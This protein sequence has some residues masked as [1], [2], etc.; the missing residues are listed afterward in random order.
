MQNDLKGIN[1]ESILKRLNQLSEELKA[2]ADKTDILRL[3]S[4]K[5][6]KISVEG[7]FKRVW[8]EIESLKNWLSQLDDQFQNKIK[9]SSSAPSSSGISSDQMSL[10]L[11]KIEKLEH[12]LQA[13]QKIVDELN[14]KQRMTQTM[15]TN[16]G[17]AKDDDYIN[18]SSKVNLLIQQINDLS[19][20]FS[21]WVKE[22]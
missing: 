3:E 5:A 20:N 19:S 8:R 14:Q 1:I 21:K 22:F 15:S 10:I 17:D 7:E 2:K 9:S 4:E 16:F 18:L 12:S 6:E 13:L 11:G